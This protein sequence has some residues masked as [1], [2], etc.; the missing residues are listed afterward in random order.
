MG[1]AGRSVTPQPYYRL[2]H[3]TPQN[4]R[5]QFIRVLHPPLQRVRSIE[6]S[7]HR[8]YGACPAIRPNETLYAKGV[9][10]DTL[11]GPCR[12]PRS[13]RERER[14]REREYRGDDF[15]KKGVILRLLLLLLTKT[16]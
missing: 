11:A 6:L 15:D 3:F 9:F 4:L 1:D 8:Y 2:Q 5:F 7:R 10:P 13:K 16:L 14:E 12:Q